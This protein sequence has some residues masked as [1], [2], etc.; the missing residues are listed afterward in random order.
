M[1]C[2]FL[3]KSFLRRPAGTIGNESGKRY[4][5]CT[6]KPYSVLRVFTNQADVWDIIFMRNQLISNKMWAIHL[7]CCLEIHIFV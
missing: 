1:S 2:L 3:A 5:S 6:G 7:L 4:Q